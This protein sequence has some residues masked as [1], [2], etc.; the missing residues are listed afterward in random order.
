MKR[1]ALVLVIALA[2]ST[3]GMAV[4]IAIST[5]AGWYSQAA[6]DREMQEIVDNITSV[7]VEV[8]TAADQDALAAWVRDHTG[9]GASDLLILNGQ[10][11]ATIYAPGNTQADGSLAELFLDDGNCIINTGDY[12]FYV[13]DGAGTNGEGGIRAMMDIAGITMWDD[14]TPVV[15]TAE[16]QEYTPT[17]QDFATDRPFH[18]D[19]LEGDWYAEL[20]LAQNAAGTRADPVI[21]ANSA[22]GGRLGIFYQTASQDNDP[23]GEVISEWINNWYLPNLGGANPLARRPNPK[24]ESMVDK[25]WAQASWQ[26]GDFAVLHDVYFGASYETVL[27]ATPDDANLYVGRQAVTQLSIGVAGGP[28]PDGLVPGNTYYWRVDEVNEAEPNSPWKGKVWSF[29]VR[30]EMAWGPFPV[31]GM[32]RVDPN[33]DLSWELGMSVVFHTV[34]FGTSFDEVDSAVAGMMTADPTYDPG[35]L[36]LDTTY[37][38]RVDEFAFPANVTHRGPVWSFTTRG[39]GGGVKAEY[40][41]GM[42]LAGDPVLAQIEPTIDHAWGD[43]AVA[44]GLTDGVSARWRGELEVPFTETY[45]LITTTDDGVR[46]WLDGRMVID[47]WTDHGTTDDVAR[48]DLV[49]GQVYSIQME[50]YEN[51]GGAVAQLSWQSPSLARQIIPQGW[52]QLPLRATAPSPVHGAPHAPQAPTLTWSPGDEATG[53]DVYFGDDAEAVA[54]ADTSAGVY[55]GRQ[56]ADETSFTP[57]T[58]EW[59]KTYYWRVDEVNPD[60]P[61]SPWTGAVWSFTTADFLVVEDFEAYDDDMDAGT[62]LFQTWIDGVDN[63]T[64]SYVG[65]EVASNGTFGETG[66]V[67]SGFQ[68]MPLDYNNV[69]APYYAETD[70]TWSTAKNWTINDIDALTLHIQGSAG[71]DP[72]PLYIALEDTAGHVAVVDYGDETVTQSP[73]WLEWKIPLSQFT[74]VNPAAVKA[75]HIGLGDRDNPTPGGAGVIYIDDIWVMKPDATQ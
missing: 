8:F 27:A 74:G 57:G 48:V 60:N 4:D 29:T 5:Q 61:D 30:P 42:A 40:F 59:G 75:M 6:A 51:G 26:A 21:V 23:R 31:D 68:S 35:T 20:I 32:Q 38:W 37:Y 19:E 58:L 24:D 13:V 69:N 3:K 25:T 36:E 65:Y 72:A 47:N 1:L 15:V 55:Q 10:F 16:G 18:L 49:A 73:D 62:A 22:T 28:A 14:D 41:E 52:L 54:G 64:T 34:F 70:R 56:A 9:D 71:N 39:A 17:L 67:H 53:H 50:Y 46:L 2:F 43:G 7:S 45:R 44:A 12:M 63:G 33:Q 66:V 11:P